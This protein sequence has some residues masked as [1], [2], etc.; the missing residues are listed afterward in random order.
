MKGFIVVPTHVAAQKLTEIST[1]KNSGVQMH[2]IPELSHRTVFIKMK[3]SQ[4]E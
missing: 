4:S 2:C 3:A 1:G